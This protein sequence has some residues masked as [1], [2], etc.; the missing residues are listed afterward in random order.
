VD[1]IYTAGACDPAM[2]AQRLIALRTSLGMS[3]AAFADITGIDR[4]SYTKIEKG[5]K[6]LLPPSAY[7]ICQLYGVDMNYL[8][9][10]RIDG[11][12]VKLSNAVMSHLEGPKNAKSWIQVGTSRLSD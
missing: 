6:P 4:S 2:V 9:M 5:E 3:R 12:A 10:G 8:Y 1:E 11:L 7:R